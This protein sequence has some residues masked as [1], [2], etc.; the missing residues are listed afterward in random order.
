M[1]EISWLRQSPKYRAGFVALGRMDRM[2]RWWLFSVWLA[3][4]HPA[5]ADEKE[6]ETKKSTSDE[7]I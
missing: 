4:P 1:K 3:A 2:C 6:Q 5:A 7:R